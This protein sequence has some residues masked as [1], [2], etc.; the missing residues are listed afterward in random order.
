MIILVRLHWPG[1]ARVG[2]GYSFPLGAGP[3][4]EL[5][6]GLAQAWP[7]LGLRVAGL[8]LAVGGVEY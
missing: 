8:L 7:G 2:Q 3:V 1:L 5:L 4:F 6:W